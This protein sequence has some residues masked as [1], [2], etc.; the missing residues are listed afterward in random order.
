MNT[1]R[2]QILTDAKNDLEEG[3]QFY[4]KHGKNVGDYFWDSLLS[5]IE[6]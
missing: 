5:D 2:I 4:D 1:K 3:R 6:S